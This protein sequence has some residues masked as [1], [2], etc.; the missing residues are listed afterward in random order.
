MKR[1]ATSRAHAFG[2][3]ALRDLLELLLA[4]PRVADAVPAAAVAATAARRAVNHA[5]DDDDDGEAN[6]D[7][8]LDA[9]T[10]LIIDELCANYVASYDDVKFYTLDALRC[11]V[12]ECALFADGAGQAHVRQCTPRARR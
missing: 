4:P 7:E 6:V 5:A 11:V 1:D 2:T 3:G 9:T 12:R 8:A 10:M